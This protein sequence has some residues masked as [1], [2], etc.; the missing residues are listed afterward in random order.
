MGPF[1]NSDFT[2]RLPS[3]PTPVGNGEMRLLEQPR[4]G[5]SCAPGVEGKTISPA[6]ARWGGQ[7]HQR[8]GTAGVVPRSLLSHPC[9]S[10]EVLM[11]H[12]WLVGCDPGGMWCSAQSQTHCPH[13][14]A[15]HTSSSHLLSQVMGDSSCSGTVSVLQG[16]TTLGSTGIPVTFCS[17]LPTRPVHPQ[18]RRKR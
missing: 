1:L 11:L 5:E 2:E 4:D 18:H 7:R 8:A 6:D 14:P 12:S 16:C 10:C 3:S 15:L 13:P 17:M 9:H